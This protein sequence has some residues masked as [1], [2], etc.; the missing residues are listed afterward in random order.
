MY[1]V[2][3]RNGFSDRNKIKEEN[4]KIQL[5]ELDERTRVKI[6]N[7]ISEWYLI[8]YDNA[9]YATYEIQEFMKY[10]LDEVYAEPIDTRISIDDNRFFKIINGTIKEG[11]YDDVLTLLE[12]IV[13]YWDAEL[14]SASP[15]SYRDMNKNQTIFD[16]FNNILKQE[17]VGYRFLNR[18]IVPISDDVEIKEISVAM[19]NP[20]KVVNEH[21][22]KA[23]LHLSNRVTPDYENS[24]KESIS[25]IEALCEIVTGLKG[26][27]ATLGNMIKKL[28]SKG[29]VIHGGL[30]SAFN[31][32][33]GYTSD[34]N[35]IRHAGD[36]GGP[37]STFAEAKFM[38][39][40]CSA[41]V[42]Y[43]LEVLSE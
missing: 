26:K 3:R 23:S 31:I 36:I 1:Q 35:G 5:R 9:Y 12:A 21:L 18:I 16:A 7:A 19:D 42:N 20:Y 34:A 38:L 40:S 24:I 8:M 41:F 43:L 30:K 17:F 6:Q 14:R 39:V 33:Y 27:D 2:R 10:V 13:Q 28:E 11:T 37:A 32:L 22:H 15:Y 4:T 29:V 25:A